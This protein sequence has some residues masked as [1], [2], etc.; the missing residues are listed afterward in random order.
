[1]GSSTTRV[2][3]DF[4]TTE[5]AQNSNMTEVLTTTDNSKTAQ[6]LFS[7]FSCSLMENL[8]K[9]S[10]S[11]PITPQ[12]ICSLFHMWMHLEEREMGK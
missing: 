2:H 3:G 4:E 6:F 10:V 9:L 12:H 5:K 8:T 7:V 1:M 11:S